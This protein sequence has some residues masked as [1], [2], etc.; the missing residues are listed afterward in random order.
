MLS[1]GPKRGFIPNPDISPLPTEGDK[2]YRGSGVDLLPILEVQYLFFSSAK[3][4]K[5]IPWIQP[6]LSLDASPSMILEEFGE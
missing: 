1:L 3:R 5:I 6:S 4:L 2:A